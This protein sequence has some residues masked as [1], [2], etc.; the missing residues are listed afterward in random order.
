MARGYASAFK[1]VVAFALVCLATGASAADNSAAPIEWIDVHTHPIGGRR[2]PDYQGAVDAAL[3]IMQESGIR[4][5]V[6]MP[7]PQAPPGNF[8][9]PDFA[10]AI[11]PHAARLSFL[12]GGGTLNVMLQQAAGEQAVPEATARRFD[13]KAAE[14]LAAGALGFGEITAH[15]LSLLPDHPYEAVAAD[16]PLLLR[17]ARIAAHHDVVIDL[18][19]DPVT[20]ELTAP[21]WMSSP[22][23]PRVFR[24][25]IDAFERLLEHDRKAKIVWAHAGSDMLGQWTVALSRKLLE[26]HPNLYMS[27][28]LGPGRAPA[29]HPLM[30]NGAI[31]AQWLEL[32]TD[33]Q[34][35]FVI[36][37]DQFFLGAGVQ[38]GPAATFAQ[39]AATNRYRTQQLLSALPEPARSKIARDNAKRIYRIPD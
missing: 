34:D 13:E 36:G 32:L 39:R 3:A 5:M 1:A 4:H 2:L 15:H 26:K 30:P 8:D 17:L 6:M 37:N 38:G 31:K 7:P 21:G 27:L 14:I 20:E 29:N 28:R 33:F 22:P 24:P 10:R 16:H 18:H 35:R 12:G 19:F 9:Y 11:K 25:N 23:N